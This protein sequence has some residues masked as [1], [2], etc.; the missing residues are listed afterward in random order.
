MLKSIFTSILLTFLFSTVVCAND[1]DS[2]KSNS[3]PQI[4]VKDIDGKSVNFAQ[5]ITPGQITIV[6]FWATWCKPCL[7]ELVNIDNLYEDW[8]KKYNVKLIAV[9]IDDSRTAPKVKPLV[10]SKNWTYE[11]L[12]D[13]NSD[14]KR[15]MNV[16]NPPTLFLIDKNGKIVFTHTGYIEGDENEL[17]KKIAELTSH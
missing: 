2:T 1:D 13:I 3:L 15:A 11:I 8:Q 7:Q 10:T 12:I 9:S 6:S 17:E 4:T 14:L 5:S 16:T